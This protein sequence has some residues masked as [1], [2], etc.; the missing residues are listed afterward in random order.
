MSDNNKIELYECPM[1]W[2]SFQ[3]FEFDNQLAVKV[4]TDKKI[5][6]K[7][8]TEENMAA[9]NKNLLTYHILW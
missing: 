6:E 9:F 7:Y 2:D 5:L 1:I 3:Y 8:P 4:A